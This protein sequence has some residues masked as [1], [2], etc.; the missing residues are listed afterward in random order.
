M[1]KVKGFK[2]YNDNNRPSFE[3]SFENLGQ[4]AYFI[5]DNVIGKDIKFPAQNADG[6]F[7]QC[8]AGSF[9][10][11]LRYCNEV[12]RNGLHISTHIELIKDQHGKILFSSGSLT[13]KMGHVSRAMKEMLENLKTWKSEAY[14]FAD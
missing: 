13:D 14:A 3:M 5:K 7:D 11:N 8:Y 2:Y 12:S 6:T 10:G 9:S 4:L 1:I